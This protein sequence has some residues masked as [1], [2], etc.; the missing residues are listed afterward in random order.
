MQG[1]RCLFDNERWAEP[2]VARTSME[3]SWSRPD[4]R[5]DPVTAGSVGVRLGSPADPSATSLGSAVALESLPWSVWVSIFLRCA[6]H[7]EP[8]RRGT[9]S[10]AKHGLGSRSRLAVE[11]DLKL[12]FKDH[13]ALIRAVEVHRD[14]AAPGQSPRRPPTRPAHLS[15]LIAKAKL[16]RSARVSFRPSLDQ[17]ERPQIKSLL[18]P[19]FS[20]LLQNGR[21][22]IPTRPTLAR[23]DHTDASPSGETATRWNCDTFP[24]WRWSH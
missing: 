24:R 12:A 10:G 15:P 8:R 19:R 2:S 22:S 16:T 14:A 3:L 13:V 4:L 23:N 21:A 11:L 7:G 5:S 1:F 20:P 6:S 18:G 9:M 17:L